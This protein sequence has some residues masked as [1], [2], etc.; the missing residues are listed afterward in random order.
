MTQDEIQS[1]FGGRIIGNSFVKA[2]VI[3]AVSKL[4][5]DLQDQIVKTTWFFSSD[6]DSWG[7]AFDG[8]D[9]KNKKLIFLSDELF[10]EE[11]SQILYTILHEIGHIILNHK[12]SIN[13]KQTKIEIDQQE[14]EAD[15]FAK[16]YL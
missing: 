4:P 5:E 11:D 10:Y 1:G 14:S 13:Y 8:N 15:L 12:N 16:K 7:Y 9:L 6:K 3:A 2:K